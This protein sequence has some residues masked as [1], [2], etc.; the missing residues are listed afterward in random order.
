MRSPWIMMGCIAVFLVAM[1]V[2]TSGS[3]TDDESPPGDQVVAAPPVQLPPVAAESAAT[4][5]AAGP[6]EEPGVVAMPEASAAIAGV[7]SVACPDDEAGYEWAEAHR[8]SNQADCAGD[9]EPFNEGCRLY[10]E[11]QTALSGHDDDRPSSVE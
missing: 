7:C 4:S 6:G 1:V 5:L 3:F 10:V 11:I 8:I 2:S 9:S